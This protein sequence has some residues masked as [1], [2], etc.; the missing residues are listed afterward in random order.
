M[1]TIKNLN[2]FAVGLPI[3]ILITYPFFKEGSLLFALLS[4]MVTGFI[5]FCLGL[6]LLFETPNNS[7]FQI[8]IASVLVFFVLWFI[9]AQTGYEKITSYIL[10]SIP[11]LLA[12]YL[13]ILIYKIPNR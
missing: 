12:I 8:Y 4:T 11:V 7:K 10:I 6:I 9:T 3:A 2:T 5:Q 1:K 13:S